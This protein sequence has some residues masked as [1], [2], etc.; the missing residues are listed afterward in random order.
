MI[1]DM[2]T[3]KTKDFFFEQG[4]KYF[5]TNVHQFMLNSIRTKILE[6]TLFGQYRGKAENVA[7]Q[8]MVRQTRWFKKVITI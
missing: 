7:F 1:E 8:F 4:R 3:K 2:P 5:I 6:T